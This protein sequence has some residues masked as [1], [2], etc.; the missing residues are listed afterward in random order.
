VIA[1]CD[2]LDKLKS[3]KALPYAFTENFATMAVSVLNS[4]KAGK[5]SV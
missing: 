2:Y 1:N 3:S 4:L 5:V